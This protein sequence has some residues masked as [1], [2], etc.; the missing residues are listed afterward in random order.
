MHSISMSNSIGQEPHSDEGPGGR[1]RREEACIDL[2]D[3]AEMSRVCGIDRDLAH[4]IQRRASAFESVLHGLERQLVCVAMSPVASRPVLRSIGGRPD[5]KTKPLALITGDSGTPARRMPSETTGMS[6]TV[7]S[8]IAPPCLSNASLSF[9]NIRG[10]AELAGRMALITGGR[11]TA[12][13][14]RSRKRALRRSEA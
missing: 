13:G 5:T 4:L 9:G 2:V 10:H 7:R 14:A 1:S 8:M 11:P 12:S 6:T 3:G